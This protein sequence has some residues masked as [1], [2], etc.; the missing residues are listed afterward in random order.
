M[1]LT[2]APG[3]EEVLATF[4]NYK[5]KVPAGNRVYLTDNPTNLTWIADVAVKIHTTEV[6]GVGNAQHDTAKHIGKSADSAYCPVNAVDVTSALNI[7]ADEY[8]V[9][10]A[11]LLARMKEPEAKGDP[12]EPGS[13]WCYENGTWGW[14]PPA[15][16]GGHRC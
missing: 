6:G 1:G 15:G 13:T 9:I 11:D 2:D 3:T 10:T 16:G 14:C 8:A 5:L 7:G 4:S 12:L